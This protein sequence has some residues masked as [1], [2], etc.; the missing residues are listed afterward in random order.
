MEDIMRL[1]GHVRLALAG[2]FLMVVASD[3]EAT[4]WVAS[5]GSGTTCSQTSPCAG[6]LTQA[7]VSANSGD[8]IRC[9]DDISTATLISITKSITINCEDHP[10]NLQGSNIT[11][12]V[13]VSDAVKLRGIEFEE[14]RGSFGPFYAIDFNGTGLLVL[15]HVQIKGGL[16]GFGGVGFR[17]NGSA[18]LVMSDCLVADNG[19]G[20]N[21]LIRPIGNAPVQASINRVTT[22]SSVFGIKVD[23]GGQTAGVIDVEVRDSVAAGHTNNGF[24]AV[25]SAGQAQIRFKI[26]RSSAS[27]NGAFGAV[28]TGAQAFMI[29]DGSSFTGNGTGLAQLSGST[30]ASYGNTAV[31]FNTTNT[32]GTITPIALN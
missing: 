28:A 32:S 18:K 24:I 13:S 11:I 14:G 8:E 3:A 26:T 25:S 21:I 9:V 27:G 1:F 19:S 7:L 6:T 2:I 22:A 5:F 10:I 4:L 29:V 16:G 23:G 17:P 12:T 20:G 31:N 15:D 30:V